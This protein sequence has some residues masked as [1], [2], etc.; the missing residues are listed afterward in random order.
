MKTILFKR[1]ALLVAAI[2]ISICALSQTTEYNI[3]WNAGG[4]DIEIPSQE[5]ETAAQVESAVNSCLTAEGVSWMSLDSVESGS[6]SEHWLL[7][8]NVSNNNSQT[9]RVAAFATWSFCVIQAAQNSGPVLVEPYGGTATVLPGEAT[10]VVVSNLP[11]SRR[12]ALKRRPLSGGTWT[13]ADTLV[14]QAPECSVNRILSDGEYL[15]DS[16]DLS[17]TVRYKD[18]LYY[19]FYTTTQGGEASWSALPIALDKDG[20][21]NTIYFSAYTDESGISHSASSAVANMLEELFYWYNNGYCAGW[22]NDIQIHADYASGKGIIRVVC[23][24]N[25]GA[26]RSWDTGLK[27]SGHDNTI[28]YSQ[29]SGGDLI[30]VN[31]TLSS[32]SVSLASSQ[33]LVLYTVSDSENSVAVSGDGAGQTISLSASGITGAYSVTATCNGRRRLIG[34]FVPENDTPQAEGA[35]EALGPNSIKTITHNGELSNSE[36]LVY[37]DGLGRAKQKVSVRASGDM[38]KDLV[39]QVRP[40]HLGREWRSYL[41]FPATGSSGSYR[42]D[43]Y[44]NQASWWYS[45]GGCD[46]GSEYAY[47]TTLL[48]ASV[49]GRSLTERLPGED[50]H[51]TGHDT[52]YSYTAG[53]LPKLSVST[54]GSLSVDGTYAAQTLLCSSVQ[55]GD[56]RITLTYTD[57]EGRTV[58]DGPSGAL[59]YYAYDTCGRLAWMISP[60]GVSHMSGNGPWAPNSDFAQ[61]YCYVYLYDSRGRMVEKRLPGAEP[62]Y[63][64]YDNGD[65]PVF[66]QDG[67]MRADGNKWKATFYDGCGRMVRED[68]R[69]GDAFT[70]AQLQAAFDS[71]NTHSLYTTTTGVTLLHLQVWD[72]Y[73]Q[74]MP[75]D[76]AFLAD[77]VA[78]SAMLRSSH[79]GLLVYEELNVLGTTQY[80]KRTRYYD[81]EDRVIQEV[82]LC[83]TGLP[84]RT[85][86][87]YDLRGNVVCTRSAT[88]MEGEIHATLVTN[89]EYDARGRLISSS[90]FLQGNQISSETFTYDDLG[91]LTSKTY[92]NGVTDSYD[93]NLQ[94]WKTTQETRLGNT[95]LF[96]STLRYHDAFNSVTIPSWT[97][98][99]SSWSWTQSGQDERTYVFGYDSLDRLVTT[100]QYRNNS[101]ENKYGEDLSYDLNGNITSIGRRNGSTSTE[102]EYFTYTGNKRSGWIYDYNGNAYPDQP[103][104]E[105]PIQIEYNLLNLPSHISAEEDLATTHYLADGT[106][107]AMREGND[108]GG[109]NY[110]GPFRYWPDEPEI[111]DVEVAGGRAVTTRAGW[112]MRYYTT[113]H[114][115]STRLITDG[116]G[117]IIRQY[118]YLPYGEKCYNTG[119]AFGYSGNTDYLYCGKE[120]LEFFGIDWY[121]SKY[122][123][124][125]T[126]GIFTSIDPL[127]EK[128]P[129]ISPYAYCAGNPVETVDE[130]GEMPHI[131][132]GAIAG[133]VINGGIAFIKGKT[134]KEVLGAAVGGALFGAITASSFGA[135]LLGLAGSSVLQGFVGGIAGSVT[136]QAIGSGSIEVGKT[137]MDGASGVIAG[138]ASSYVSGALN[139]VKTSAMQSIEQKY[140]SNAVQNAIRKEIKSEFRNTGKSFGKTTKKQL[141]EAVSN[142]IET[143]K[144]VDITVTK[145]IMITVDETQQQAIGWGMNKLTEWAHEKTQ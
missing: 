130:D 53:S 91:R 12:I 26:A 88:N 51:D 131:V 34:K 19:T 58:A 145:G 46:Q 3:T 143:L 55:D 6:D 63:F 83:P 123:Y 32:S 81:R 100:S 56:G 28:S 43:A 126:E 80:A 2:M 7:C 22:N 98:D 111:L 23:P 82:L 106:K 44:T 41:P 30:G 109:I 135:N 69:N 25:F 73:P 70:R 18:V 15:L 141:N 65:R 78:T 89:N 113:D 142:R 49:A 72:T 128:Y 90:S 42:S 47:T 137:L 40:D 110:I 129:G 33:Y 86:F 62:Q 77:T 108:S 50:Y 140:E 17:F 31:A 35:I 115:G 87:R 117:A 67:N 64:V 132:I 97:G 27:Y 105:F 75:Q 122:R 112:A 136:E 114:L 93:Y 36:D 1:A 9:S 60:E 29:P 85:S 24:P 13:V 92:G 4:V 138:I 124:L 144:E 52:D 20:A 119:L 16:L 101:L 103:D 5:G 116:S 39:K 102:T 95:D 133:G 48:E 127:A 21:T 139:N 74:Q 118:D 11:A 104:E 14:L 121:D 134:G 57:R 79:K 38:T 8:F 71:S 96:S 66:F 107:I 59:T 68:L 54:S 120:W 45:Q 61:K 125:S 37:Y 84:V 99:I 76:L 94:G 10:R